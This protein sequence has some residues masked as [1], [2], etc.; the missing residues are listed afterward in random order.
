MY[1]SNYSMYLSLISHHTYKSFTSFLESFSRYFQK[2]GAFYF[3]SVSMTLPSP[4]HSYE[5]LLGIIFF[6]SSTSS[7]SYSVILSSPSIQY[8]Y[9]LNLSSSMC[10]SLS[11]LC[12]HSGVFI[13]VCNLIIISRSSVFYAQYT[14]GLSTGNL[15]S[16]C[17]FLI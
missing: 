3:L 15:L 10:I 4:R 6:L 2:L 14:T 16:S 1:S 8:A 5:L 12:L 17:L 13:I 11:K 7:V 9:S